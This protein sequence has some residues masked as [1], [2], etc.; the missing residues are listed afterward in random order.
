MPARNL[1]RQRCR[2]LVMCCGSEMDSIPLQEIW[3]DHRVVNDDADAAAPKL[4]EMSDMVKVLE[5]WENMERSCE[6][7]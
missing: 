3:R 4:W 7:S 6:L 5:D 2:D 1:R